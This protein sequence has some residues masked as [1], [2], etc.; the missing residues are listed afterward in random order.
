[1]TITRG[2]EYLGRVRACAGVRCIKDR[3]PYI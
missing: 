2:D 1:M 3:G